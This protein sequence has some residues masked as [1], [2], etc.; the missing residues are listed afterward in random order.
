MR[1]HFTDLMIPDKDPNY[2][3]DSSSESSSDCEIQCILSNTNS[4]V[5]ENTNVSAENDATIK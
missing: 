3:T 5:Q 1:I 4:T 2:S